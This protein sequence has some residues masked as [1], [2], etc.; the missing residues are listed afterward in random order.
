[1]LKT[2]NQMTPE[3]KVG[4]FTKF[5]IEMAKLGF[6]VSD[7]GT[8][9]MDTNEL[10]QER[11]NLRRALNALQDRTTDAK[12]SPTEDELQMMDIAATL[13]AQVS[14]A[15]DLNV[16]AESH[17]GRT[18]RASASSSG[19]RDAEGRT[20]RVLSKGERVADAFPRSEGIATV[21]FGEVIRM[22]AVGQGRP[23][24]RNAL[25]EGTNSAGGYTVPTYLLGELIDRL[26]SQ[27]VAIQ[28]GARTVMLDTQKVS[29]ARLAT[30]PTVSWRS[31]NAAVGTGDPTFEN[32]QFTA[33]SLACLVKCS[34]ELIEDSVNL[35]EALRNAFAQ[36]MALEIDR[37]ALLGT[38]TPPEPGGIFTTANVNSVSMG[39]NGAQLTNWD[40]VLDALYEIE[41]DNGGTVTALAMHPRTW[42]TIQKFK[43]STNQ[44]LLPP[45]GVAE[46]PMLRTTQIPITQTQ[47]TSND[48][49]SIIGG[50]F[51]QLMI[52]VRSEL[53]IQLL[54][55]LYAENG[56]FGFVA[57]LRADV[58]LAHPESFVKLIG[59]KP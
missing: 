59:I 46:I 21:G 41:L 44:P 42:R 36:A 6:Q 29:I 50:N 33:R 1:M 55:E 35:E 47:G 26:R 54:R 58:Q 9:Q 51:E 53:S 45:P 31:E 8:T 4:A 5:K 52:G 20:V 14:N 15:I 13:I 2:W 18:G 57:H 27:S 56:Q 49:S 16:A 3:E 40:N 34:R 17:F 43:D 32:V 24:V 37:V 19:W 22:M 11:A 48:C 12:R 38:G 39:T 7:K 23:E 30:D 25:S 10:H 28:A